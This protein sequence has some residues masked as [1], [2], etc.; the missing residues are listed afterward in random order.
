MTIT[1][2]APQPV[3]AGIADA[4]APW[5]LHGR[6]YI[7]A[8]KMP[9]DVLDSDPWTPDSLR[10]SRKGAVALVMLVDYASSPAGPYQELLF[11]P[12]SFRFGNQR[13]PSISRIFVSSWES[14]H[15]GRRNWGIPKDR[16]DFDMRYGLPDGTDKARLTAEDGDFIAE[17]TLRPRGPS[18]PMPGNWVPAALRTLSQHWEGRQFTLAPSAKGRLRWAKVEGWRFNPAQFPDLARGRCIAAFEIPRFEMVFPE[19]RVSPL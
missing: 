7:L 18:L 6:G 3:P 14:V 17:L 11:I 15:N 5:L 10:A 4:P 9:D 8:V 2:Y 16:C 12:G 1:R 19:P 13:H